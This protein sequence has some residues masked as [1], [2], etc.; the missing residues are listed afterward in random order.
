MLC[1]RPIHLAAPYKDQIVSC[2]QCLACRINRRRKW[3]ARI[4]LEAAG[5]A[6]SI[7]ITLTYSPETVP[8]RTI[9]GDRVDVLKKSDLQYFFRMMRRD[10]H[11]DTLR[12]FACGEYGTK[13]GRPHYHAILFGKHFTAQME[14]IVRHTWGKGFIT[15]SELNE[16]RA[17]YVAA[18]TIKKMTQEDSRGLNGR[19]PEFTLQSRKPGIG[20]EAAARLANMYYRRDGAKALADNGDVLHVVRIHGKIYPLDD[21]MLG[22]M[23]VI[24]D[25]PKL[26]AD[27]MPTSLDT[28]EPDYEA[29]AE[30][31]KHLEISQ[32][33]H[34]TL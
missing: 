7:F 19:P 15:I 24:L 13:D 4:L 25:I 14:A 22:K 23:R 34:G 32:R 33:P 28:K 21:F 31:L 5:Y 3:T 2:G 9:K 17:A 10:P 27:R 20:A 16:K 6:Q 29:A 26:R 30:T 1:G 8:K 12:Y 11:I 18:Y